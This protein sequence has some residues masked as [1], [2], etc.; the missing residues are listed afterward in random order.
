MLISESTTDAELE[1]IVIDGFG[2]AVWNQ[3]TELDREMS[4]SNAHDVRQNLN[5]TAEVQKMV[6]SQKRHIPTSISPNISMSARGPS[7]VLGQENLAA[8]G[9]PAGMESV[10]RL[11][12][13]CRT[14]A[15]WAPV[16][17]WLHISC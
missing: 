6:E 16:N 10:I 2:L 5:D 7:N 13:E 3:M 14:I 17:K 8:A 9:C 11:H 4:L 15:Q 1:A 12:T